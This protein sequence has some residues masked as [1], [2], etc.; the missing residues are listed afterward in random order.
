M[1]EIR[2]PEEAA[3][4]GHD[5]QPTA[6]SMWMAG[7]GIKSGHVHGATDGLCL[8]IT[9]D[10][11]HVHDLQA[12]ILHQLGFD[13]EKFTYRFM[14][15]DFQLTDVSGS[16]QTGLLAL[17]FPSEGHCTNWLHAGR[18]SRGHATVIWRVVLFGCASGID[19][20]LWEPMLIPNRRS[21]AIRNG[22]PASRAHTICQ[23]SLR[24]RLTQ[25]FR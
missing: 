2:K 21:A 24:Q 13:H 8:N 23:R 1:V 25:G 18:A 11:V 22:S 12:T 20:P 4:A 19:Q 14:G 17:A 7:G 3:N 9:K 5:H 15:S 10:P 6:Y 16:V